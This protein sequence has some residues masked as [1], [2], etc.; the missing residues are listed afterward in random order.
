VK[1]KSKVDVP[2]ASIMT[3]PVIGYNSIALDSLK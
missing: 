1:G 2:R 3:S